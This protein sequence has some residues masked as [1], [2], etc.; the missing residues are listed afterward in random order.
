[1]PVS[2]DLSFAEAPESNEVTIKKSNKKAF[3]Y[4]FF[5]MKALL[6]KEEKRLRLLKEKRF[7]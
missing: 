2:E 5:S 6:M 4:V 1:M 7:H 3:H